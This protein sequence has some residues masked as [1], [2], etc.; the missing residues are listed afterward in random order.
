MLTHSSND[1]TFDALFPAGIRQV[2]IPARNMAEVDTQLP[3]AIRA[4]LQIVPVRTLQEVLLAAFDPPLQLLPE[5][6]L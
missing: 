3:P 4:Q 2:I 1:A 5:A 6:K